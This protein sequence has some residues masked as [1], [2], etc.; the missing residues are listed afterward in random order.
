MFSINRKHIQ[1]R[2]GNTN[3][4]IQGEKMR[5]IQYNS[6]TDINIQFED[7]GNVLFHQC[8]SNFLRGTLKDYY[9]PTL[10]GKGILE[11]SNIYD[12]NG[13]KRIEFIYWDGMMKRCYS[14]PELKKYPSYKG[15][16]VCNEWLHFSQFETWFS[17]NYYQ[18]GNEKMNL[19]KDI[20]YKGNKLYSPNT[21]IFVPERINILFT[22]TNRNRGKYPIGVYYKKQNKKFVAQVSKLKNEE[23]N[24]KK[25]EYLGM[26]DT[27]EDAFE[28]YK[29]EKEKY[30]KEVADC[31]RYKY[32][33]FP[34]ELYYALYNYKVE[35]TD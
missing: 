13:N 4:N 31:Y 10:Y 24:T 18:C 19:D 11:N 34:D 30:I 21:T 6:A 25:Q 15:C 14:E 7:T 16:S 29:K 28:V 8:Y 35:I 27:P 32:S 2:L 17:Q 22:K 5:I 9:L 3:I 23:L 12:E 20:L 33:N 26:F 1:E